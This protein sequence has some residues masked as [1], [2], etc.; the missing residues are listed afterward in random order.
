MELL[1]AIPTWNR[2][3][4]LDQLRQL[5]RGSNALELTYKA[6]WKRILQQDSESVLLAKAIL[7]W[8]CFT[9]IP[10]DITTFRHALTVARSDLTSI[11]DDMLI[12][13]DLIS[14]VCLGLVVISETTG[15]V[16]FV[17]YTA[18]EF[19]PGYL[20]REIPDTDLIV[21]TSCIRYLSIDGFDTNAAEAQL[22]SALSQY[23]LLE[24]AATTWG[25]RVAQSSE[26]GLRPILLRFLKNPAKVNSAARVLV[27]CREWKHEGVP[28]IPKDVL[29]L[30]LAAYFG[31]IGTFCN[32]ADFDEPI[33]V[34]DSNGWTPLRWAAYGDQPMVIELLIKSGSNLT[35]TDC[36][37]ESTLMWG[38]GE[39]VPKSILSHCTVSSSA[40]LLVGDIQ[41]STIPPELQASPDGHVEAR[42]SKEIIE[43]LIAKTDNIDL[44]NR[45][46]RTALSRAAE[47]HQVSHV[48]QLLERGADRN[49]EDN[50]FMTALLWALQWP[51]GAR[52]TRHI[53]NTEVSGDSQVVIGDT[54]SVT[55][56]ALQSCLRPSWTI[57]EDMIRRLIGS[58]YK[59]KDMNGK[60]TLALAAERSYVEIVKALLDRIEDP[61]G[62]EISTMAPLTLASQR[63]CFQQIIVDGLQVTDSARVICGPV[64]YF[65]DGRSALEKTDH[66]PSFFQR[67]E[68][69]VNLYLD[70]IITLGHQVPDLTPFIRL[71]NRDGL[72]NVAQVLRKRHR[73]HHGDTTDSADV[74]EQEADMDLSRTFQRG[75]LHITDNGKLTAGSFGAVSTKLRNIATH[76][77]VRITFQNSSISDEAQVFVGPIFTN[78]VRGDLL[79]DMMS[80]MSEFFEIAF[81]STEIHE[82]RIAIFRGDGVVGSDVDS[83]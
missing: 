39:P 45:H 62:L 11:N 82:G 59:A 46:G 19:F 28:E 43:I 36:N 67:R 60:S 37:G 56:D 47:N 55:R 3:V 31:L 10:R 44:A 51:W 4:Y 74:E 81:E 2:D 27:F 15:Q 72:T 18:Q 17:H 77:D 40:K 14:S 20:Q 54:H 53:K 63:P 70:K 78:A 32:L 80:R 64:F 26:K 5:P 49:L 12:K 34:M 42:T 35:S 6:F 38:L 29:G 61:D 58:N 25:S 24:F 76:S 71:A 68:D 48:S 16:R 1:E 79:T 83:P 7:T 75:E 13:P 57:T 22:A 21:A 50:H 8:L 69:I 33:D 65:P 23:P 66:V 9:E 73:E 41:S 30:H 52:N